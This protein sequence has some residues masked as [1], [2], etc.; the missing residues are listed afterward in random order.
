VREIKKITDGG[1]TKE[2][3]K[4]NNTRLD[5]F[6][7]RKKGKKNRLKNSCVD[8]DRCMARV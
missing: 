8:S 6:P 5:Q 4:N 1:K 3:K 2:K 7:V